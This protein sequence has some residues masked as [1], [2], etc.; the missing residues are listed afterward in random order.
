MDLARGLGLA[1]EQCR[2]GGTEPV[3][4]VD[5]RGPLFVACEIQST[6]KFN[7]GT[8]TLNAHRGL[9]SGTVHSGASATV[10]LP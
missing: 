9:L 4:V 8:T 7:A 10:Q 3:V 1:D 2:L 6:K 5:S